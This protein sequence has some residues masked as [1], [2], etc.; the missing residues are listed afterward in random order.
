MP[1]ET[2]TLLI[3]DE[4]YAPPADF[5]LVFELLSQGTSLGVLS[6]YLKRRD[7]PHSAGSW[8]E[9]REKR[10]LPALQKNLLSMSDL[11]LLLAEVEE[12][13]RAH[14]F[15]FRTKHEIAGELIERAFEVAEQS[16]LGDCIGHG[17]VLA[18][19]SAPTIASIR[20]EDDARGRALVLK[21]V[22]QRSEHRFIRERREANRLIMEWEI[23]EVRAVNVARLLS[24]G[25][26]ELRIASHRSSTRYADDLARVWRLMEAFIPRAA[27][28]DY[29]LARAK[30][31]LLSRR[32]ELASTIRFSNS[33]LRDTTGNTLIASSGIEEGDLFQASALS[34]SLGFFIKGGNVACESLNLYW[35]RGEDGLPSKDV[36]L[37]L[38]E[39]RNEFAIPANCAKA[40]YEYVFDQLR[41]LSK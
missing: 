20:I 32:A 25:L 1:P 40:D 12:F 38:P 13:G 5:N 15:L 33:A 31:E 37:L 21:V 11:T 24:S 27:F 2:Q 35:L 36:H 10:V 17:K 14:T 7:L 29:S 6:D 16:G 8:K 26:L 18:Q 34:E 9:L 28:F 3:A 39:T 22:E 30:S 19:P 23:S 4:G 41:A